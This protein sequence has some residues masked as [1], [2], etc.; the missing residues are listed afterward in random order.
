V[1]RI[2][3]IALA[4]CGGAA[5]PAAP[6]A[7]PAPPA[8]AMPAPLT[9]VYRLVETRRHHATRTTFTLVIDGARTTLAETEET[10]DTGATWQPRATHTYRGT[11]RVDANATVLELEAA[12]IQP[13]HL[14]C[15]QTM[16]K[17]YKRVEPVLAC[18]ESMQPATDDPDDDDRLLFGDGAGLER[19]TDNDDDAETIRP[20]R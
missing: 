15:V 11:A 9:R 10:S 16:V 1:W 13:L 12:G 6:P 8:R 3:V 17:L 7:P 18:G 4:A 14:R 5:A 20:I 2:A 19:E